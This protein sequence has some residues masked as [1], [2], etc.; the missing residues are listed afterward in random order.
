MLILSIYFSFQLRE[1]TIEGYDSRKYTDQDKNKEFART[2]ERFPLR[3]SFQDGIVESVCPDIDDI[4]WAVNIKKGI[5]SSFQNSMDSFEVEH[6]GKEVLN[7]FH[8]MQSGIKDLKWI[9]IIKLLKFCF[10]F[11]CFSFGL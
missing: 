8:C 9:I 5:L 1:V 6:K 11:F 3:F 2:L 4:T 7:N 10:F